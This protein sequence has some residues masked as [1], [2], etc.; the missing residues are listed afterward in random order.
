MTRKREKEEEEKEKKE[1][2][3]LG[4]FLLSQGKDGKDHSLTPVRK[5]EKK[6][7]TP[8]EKSWF[9]LHRRRNR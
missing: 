7:D 8:T 5:R 9:F 2:I 6:K 3:L 1:S 4:G